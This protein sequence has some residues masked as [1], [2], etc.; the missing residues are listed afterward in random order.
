MKKQQGTLLIGAIILLLVIGF[1]AAEIA[2]ISATNSRSSS[3]LDVQSEANHLAYLGL[4]YGL[5]AIYQH[6][7][8]CA[9]VEAYVAGTMP[10]Y[11]ATID[12]VGTTY[13][14]ITTLSSGITNSVAT[15]PVTSTSGFSDKGAIRVG[16]ESIDYLNINVNDF[17]D[18]SRGAQLTSASSHPSAT[19][20][21]QFGCVIAATVTITMPGEDVVATENIQVNQ[22]PMTWIVGQNDSGDTFYEWDG[23][24]MVETGPYG[25][26]TNRPQRGIK[27]LSYSDIWAVGNDQG[28]SLNINHWDGVTWSRFN[29]VPALDRDLRGIDCISSD[30][31]VAVGQ[32]QGGDLLIVNWNGTEWSRDLTVPSVGRDLR[33]VDC[34]SSTFCLAVG[35]DEGGETLVVLYNGSVW[36]RMTGAQ[37]DSSVPSNRDLNSVHCL[38]TNYC[39]AVGQD[40]NGYVNIIFWDGSS[41]VRDTGAPSVSRDLFSV[42]CNTTSDCWAVG[43]DQGGDS[44]LLYYN[45]T[46]WARI[47]E[48]FG[49]NDLNAVTCYATNDCWVAGENSL[50][51][52]FDGT[53]WTIIAPP[54]TTELN[55]I[56]G[57]PMSGSPQ[58]FEL[59]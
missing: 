9:G 40:R 58:Y 27:V 36:T 1:A 38:A 14:N 10:S 22:L 17:I 32:D 33:G 7:A 34:L 26:V 23:V 15:I 41:W 13:E 50:I 35:Q 52:H 47:L 37:F 31:C 25:T 12:V 29:S 43:Q 2:S 11:N 18:V 28:G 55:A 20:V 21:S 49:S 5:E 30:A 44:L 8:T 16:F 42:F 56:G 48:G 3:R 19:S 6:N 53:D 39:W 46:S 45:G 59:E 4:Q 24:S 57:I 51:A 54:D